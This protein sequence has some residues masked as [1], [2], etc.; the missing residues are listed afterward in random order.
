MG[1]EPTPSLPMQG[2]TRYT[3][4]ENLSISDRD[5]PV[6][7]VC[8]G[9]IRLGAPLPTVSLSKQGRSYTYGM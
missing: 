1:T 9:H 8:Q 7:Y 4:A 3:T 2:R 6:Q 5:S